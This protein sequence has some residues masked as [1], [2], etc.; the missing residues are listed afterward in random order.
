MVPAGCL[1]TSIVLSTCISIPLAW[2]SRRSWPTKPRGAEVLFHD[3]DGMTTLEAQAAYEKTARRQTLAFLSLSL[4]GLGL[5]VVSAVLTRKKSE[6]PLRQVGWTAVGL[7]IAASVS[8]E[9]G[10]RELLSSCA[11]LRRVDR[12]LTR[13]KGIS[14]FPSRHRRMDA[15]TSLPKNPKHHCRNQ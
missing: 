5:N 14:R 11:G 4:F 13:K 3:E 15:L 12:L 7:T 9:K 1:I 10:S 2:S 8:Q 6:A